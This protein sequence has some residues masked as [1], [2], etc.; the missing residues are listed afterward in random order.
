MAIEDD[1]KIFENN[2]MQGNVLM[3]TEAKKKLEESVDGT[4][5]LLQNQELFEY[6]IVQ[7]FFNTI[8]KA[9]S[10]KKAN[11]NGNYN[12]LLSVAQTYGESVGLNVKDYL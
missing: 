10:V 4:M 3:M 8:D 12:Q 5:Y 9:I 1:I 6:G 11:L 7:G 2:A